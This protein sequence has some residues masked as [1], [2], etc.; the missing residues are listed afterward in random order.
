MASTYHLA[1]KDSNQAIRYNLTERRCCSLG[2]RKPRS[3][4]KISLVLGLLRTEVYVYQLTGT[5][6]GYGGFPVLRQI[7]IPIKRSP[8][9]IHP[10]VLLLTFCEGVNLIP[11][12]HCCVPLPTY[13]YHG[14]LHFV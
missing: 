5:L 8:Q 7:D 12:E 11:N 6:V 10:Q 13:L 1:G 9:P 14:S 3:Y 4:D 2:D